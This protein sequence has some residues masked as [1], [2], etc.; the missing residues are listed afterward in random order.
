MHRALLCFLIAVIP[1]L[2]LAQRDSVRAYVFGNSLVHFLGEENHTNVPHWVNEL[3]RFDGRTFAV[4]GQWGFLR[5]FADGLP[6]TANWSFPGVRG[7]WSPDRPFGQGR[8]DAVIVTPANFIQYQSPDI[9]YDG[10]NPTSESPLGATLRLVD[11]LS[12]QSPDAQLF[13]Y[14]GWAE[15]ATLAGGFPPSP[16]AYQTYLQANATHYHRWYVDLLADLDARRPG[17]QPRLIPVA[18]MLAGLLGPDG[19]LS[20]LP[21]TALF[22]DGDPHGTPTLYF[23]AAMITYAA[24]YETPPPATYRPPASLHP[25]VVA[26]YPDIASA[27]WQ[28]LPQFAT[29]ISEPA[30]TPARPAEPAEPPVATPTT[31]TTPTTPAETAETAPLPKREQIVLPKADQRPQGVPVLGMGLNGISDW[32]TQHPFID[33]MKTARD[34]VGHL[35]DQWGGISSQDLRANGHLSSEGWPLS[36]PQGAVALESVLLTDQPETALHLRGTYVLTYRGSGTL[37]LTGRATRVQY[38]PGEIRFSY[39]PGEG[40]VGLSITDIS[41]DDPIRE[42]RILRE[43]HMALDQAGVIFNPHWVDRIR[44]LRSLRFMDWMMTNGSPVQGWQDR[45][46]MTDATWTT[47]GVPA[48]AMIDLANLVGADPWFNMPHMADDQYVQNFAELVRDRLDPRLQAYVEYSNEVWNFIFPQAHWA[49][50][51]ARALW[52]QSETGWI[53]FYA[54]RAAQVMDIWAQVFDG[55]TERLVRTVAVHTGWPG[56]E[57]DILNAPLAYLVLRRAPVD[58]FD[59]YAVTGYF[60]HETGGDDFALRLRDWLDRSESMATAAAQSQGLRR[61]AL[62]EAVR[63]TRFDAAFAPMTQALRDGS[64]RALIDEVFPYHGSVARRAGLAL[65]MYEGGT[66]VAGHGAQVSDQRL[67]DFFTAYNYTPEMARLYQDLL[68]GWTAAGGTLFNA[69]VDVAPPSQWGSWGA[70]RHLDDSNPRWDVLMDFNA[71]GA[72]EWDSRDAAAFADGVLRQGTGRIDGTPDEDILLG[73][74]GPD[75]LVSLG[76]SDHLHGGQGTDRALL[77][78]A[79]ADYVLTGDQDRLIAT[80]GAARSVL[81]SVEELVFALEP[82]RVVTPAD[83]PA[84]LR[85]DPG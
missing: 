85:R 19:V 16:E 43:D 45:P 11:W 18:R 74:P 80:R 40:L 22:V 28:A 69:F 57:Q 6:P 15:M 65:V 46:R 62:R 83:L 10:N 32:S 64:L 8:W 54:L 82:D 1:S 35:P 24:L 30:A 72:G 34:W 49:G 20:G 9:P 70:L 25:A 29:V 42:I 52:G 77:P 78:G 71:S 36:I 84:P 33:L 37:R 17:T 60:G 68:A 58:S 61:V 48:E 41:P 79:L 63:E 66:H 38:T 50:D 31:P 76:G 23:L 21:P 26:R 73:G 3:A 67:T 75:L 5:N 4:D 39:T 53:Q 56:L 12:D 59:A 47:R 55:Q 44:D 51:Q 27:I 13:V 14:Q 7:A 81:Y 2:A